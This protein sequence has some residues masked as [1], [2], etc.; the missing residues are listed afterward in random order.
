MLDFS[1][2]P[3]VHL[4][5]LTDH[6]PK[7]ACTGATASWIAAALRRFGGVK[8]ASSNIGR[9]LAKAISAQDLRAAGCWRRQERT[10]F[11]PRVSAPRARIAAE[12]GSGTAPVAI[13]LPLVS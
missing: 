7:R 10:P 12:E 3:R 6:E 9:K 2:Q 1:A 4:E 11:A 5:L 13:G 8:S